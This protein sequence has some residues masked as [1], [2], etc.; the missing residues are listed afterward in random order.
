M[1]VEVS[2]EIS[3]IVFALVPAAMTRIAGEIVDADGQLV[4]GASIVL[5][6]PERLD[7]AITH[8][9]PDGHFSFEGVPPGRYVMQA[10]GQPPPGVGIGRAP[11]GWLSITA[12]GGDLKAL[13]VKTTTGAVVRGRVVFEGTA[14]PPKHGDVTI[15]PGAIDFES[16]PRVVAP[17]TV[18]ARSDWTFEVPHQFG[19]RVVRVLCPQP[20]SISRIAVG[21]KE[22]TDTPIDLTHGDV[23]DVEVVLTDRGAAVEGRVM[24]K[25]GSDAVD[26]AVVLFAADRDKWR[27]PS[28]FIA[29]GRPIQ[30]SRF[31]FRGLPAAEYRIIALRA[32]HDEWQ[33]PEFLQQIWFRAAPL[34]LVEGD[35]RSIDLT[36][37]R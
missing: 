12:V 16:S 6:Q 2:Q 20:W 13:V 37:S 21:V 22:I 15:L 28:R 1:H 4:S 14:A 36:L 11:F 27:F 25:D 8:P 17:P 7:S 5:M 26:Y 10:F 30:N 31:V 3:N 23:N 18:T 34:T 9:A 19:T 33:D 35:S 32:V 24:N 29:L